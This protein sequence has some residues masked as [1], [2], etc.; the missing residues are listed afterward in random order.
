[1]SIPAGDLTLM[2]SG[3]Q[4]Q[5]WYMAIDTPPTLWTARVNG[6]LSRSET[7]I[8]FDGASLVALADNPEPDV[9]FEVWFGSTEGAKDR[10]VSRVRWK[11]NSA[12]WNA[13]SGTLYI[14]T[15][16]MNLADDDYIT[17]KQN[18]RP[19]A[20]L[21]SINGTYEDEDKTYSDEGE[22]QHPLARIG[23][24]FCGF[25]SGGTVTANFWS[26]DVAI[27]SGATLASYAWNFYGG[28]PSSSAIA[29]TEGVPIEVAYTT[30][31]RYWVDHTVTDDQPKSHT[32]YTPV[33]IFDDDNLPIVAFNIDSLSGDRD[34]GSWHL[35]VTVR[36]DCT[37][38][39]FP[40]MAQVVIFTEAYWDGTQED[41]GYGWAHRDNIM[42]VGY[43]VG[44]T[45]HKDPETSF[46]SFEAVGICDI[47]KKLT[48]WGA[49]LKD[50][51]TPTRWHEIKDMDLDL[52]AFHVFTEHTTIPAI[53]DI[54]LRLQY[55][56]YA[57]VPTEISMKYTDIGEASPYDQIKNQIGEAGRALLL[58]NKYGQIYLE[59][60]A[61]LALSTNRP[62]DTMFVLTSQDW[63]DQID[64]GPEKQVY[65]A[66]QV[67]FIG[68]YY[69]GSDPLPYGS[70]APARQH[71]TGTVQKVTGVRV[72]DQTGANAYSGV[73]EQNFNNE[74]MDVMIPLAGF[75]PVFDIAP[76]RYLDITLVAG[77]TLRGLSW[78][79]VGHIPKS[80]TFSTNFAGQYALT[81]VVCEQEIGSSTGITNE[82]PIDDPSPDPPPPPPGPSPPT[83]PVAYGVIIMNETQMYLSSDFFSAINPSWEDISGSLVGTFV[84]VV[85][86]G[87]EAYASTYSIGSENLVGLWYSD[88]IFSDSPSWTLI[89]SV[90]AAATEFDGMQINNPYQTD[91][92]NAQRVNFV[93]GISDTSEVAA[94]LVRSNANTGT[95][96]W[97]I[98]NGGAITDTQVLPQ[99]G[100]SWVH[101]HRCYRPGAVSCGKSAYH[102]A[103][104]TGGGGGA[105]V[106]D[107]SGSSFISYTRNFGMQLAE[108]GYALTENLELL[109]PGWADVVYDTAITTQTAI[110]TL[111]SGV[112]YGE[113]NRYLY[114]NLVVV[115]DSNTEFS[116]AAGAGFAEFYED[117]GQIAWLTAANA[118][119]GGGLGISP[120]V[121]LYAEDA[122]EGGIATWVDKTGDFFNG[123][124][125]TWNSG[126]NVLRIF[127]Y[128]T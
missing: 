87:D 118:Q 124:L 84:D 3:P 100:A 4:W 6:D 1:M 33:H 74:F 76:Q 17:I 97:Y 19:G 111:G 95:G 53:A 20:I 59:P 123:G 81:D 67:D 56:P 85:A 46:V 5:N 128:T 71:D 55:D 43:I 9:D 41:V 58:N 49:S 22:N 35:A 68:F 63:R 125:R 23:P 96:G 24:P 2:R 25:L 18:I 104:G 65:D 101:F 57:L 122:D 86:Y 32:R 34:S 126:V 83:P 89:K 92:T 30:A 106:Y 36:E 16:D 109:G 39:D 27:A 47:M 102:F 75:W 64:L 12:A 69:S 121:V 117:S 80:V 79:A 114:R 38:S 51:S 116:A 14:A 26:D 93:L 70:L 31:G 112:L 42:F 127:L 115:G 52:S 13:A 7:D 40:D 120:Y 61:Q 45:V 8:T 48:C 110:D 82:I 54:Y 77:D 28:N 99:D 113:G 44:D 37:E 105:R 29:G 98:L 88:D 73:F 107:V 119:S 78:S 103:C 60:N 94:I 91:I 72:E 10:G 50:D 62:D 90:Q 66:C 21:P 11:G 15:N 108:G